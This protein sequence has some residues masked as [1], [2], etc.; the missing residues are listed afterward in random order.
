MSLTGIEATASPV[1]VD[2][3]GLTD[4]GRVRAT[5]EDHF[6]IANVNKSVVIHST[7]VPASTIARRFGVASAHL[8][9]VADGVGGRSDG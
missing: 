1:R 2:A 3:F 7:S 9:A 6:V 4:R 5:N 8:F